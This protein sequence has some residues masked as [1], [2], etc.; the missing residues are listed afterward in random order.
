MRR[1][2]SVIAFSAAR[3]MICIASKWSRYCV[4]LMPFIRN[5]FKGCIVQAGRPAHAGSPLGLHCEEYVEDLPIL[6]PDAELFSGVVFG[7][8]AEAGHLFGV[9]TLPVKPLDSPL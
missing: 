3:S 6:W 9:G 1:Y 4:R 2:R 7:A 5:R 8:Q